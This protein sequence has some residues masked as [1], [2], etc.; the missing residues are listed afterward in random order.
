MNIEAGLANSLAK[1]FNFTFFQPY[2]LAALSRESAVFTL[3]DL[4]F[5]II[6]SP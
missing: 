2:P 3:G 6:T 5:S 1:V 4:S